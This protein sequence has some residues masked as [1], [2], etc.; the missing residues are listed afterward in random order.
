MSILLLSTRKRASGPGGSRA[1][2]GRR[3][4]DSSEMKQIVSFSETN[5]LDRFH[6]EPVQRAG[7]LLD[8]AVRR[9]ARRRRAGYFSLAARGDELPG[10]LREPLPRDGDGSAGRS[11]PVHRDDDQFSRASPGT[12]R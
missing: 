7:A 5:C 9:G 8:L 1:P 12:G 11:G 6:E 3:R 4:S 2:K 10:F